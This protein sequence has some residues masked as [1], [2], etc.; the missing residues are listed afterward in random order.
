MLTLKCTLYRQVQTSSCS[1]SE[2]LLRINKKILYLHMDKFEEAIIR[3][4]DDS[5]KHY[6]TTIKSV[7]KA[8]VFVGV[9]FLFAILAILALLIYIEF[10]L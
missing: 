1:D 2:S 8:I 10:H 3:H 5:S 4:L 6:D 9:A 7:V